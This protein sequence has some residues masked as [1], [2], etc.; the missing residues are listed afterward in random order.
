RGLLDAELYGDLLVGAPDR[1][2]RR[3]ALLAGS[4]AARVEH[5]RRVAIRDHVAPPVGV[6][7]VDQRPAA[8]EHRA[9]RWIGTELAPAVAS[10]RDHLL[11]QLLERAS[12]AGHADRVL[13][14]ALRVEDRLGRRILKGLA[15]EDPLQPQAR[16]DVRSEAPD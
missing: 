12:H 2:E 15:G 9:P 1:R 14:L 7:A 16:R 5:A 11:P 3:H 10:A 8:A 4:E 13:R 6:K